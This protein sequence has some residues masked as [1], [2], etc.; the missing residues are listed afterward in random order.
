MV[1][2]ILVSS[3]RPVHVHVLYTC[4]CLH[5]VEGITPVSEFYMYMCRS[6]PNAGREGGKPWSHHLWRAKVN[7]IQTKFAAFP[8]FGMHPPPA[9]P[10][11]CSIT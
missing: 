9:P 7:Y 11:V 10:G 2:C 8:L 5:N 1:N 3:T 4:M 6:S